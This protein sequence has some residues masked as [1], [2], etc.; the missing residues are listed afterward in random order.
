MLLTQRT[1]REEPRLFPFYERKFGVFQRSEPHHVFTEQENSAYVDEI[2]SDRPPV[3][4]WAEQSVQATRQ[5]AGHPLD[6]DLLKTARVWVECAK[7]DLH[8][9]T[10]A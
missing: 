2:T 6:F 7:T 8:K 4:L 1:Y 9:E 10:Q 3:R 5:T